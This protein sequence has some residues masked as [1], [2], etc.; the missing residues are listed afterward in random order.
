MML[1]LAVALGIA[2]GPVEAYNQGNRLYAAK[3]FPGAV[4]AYQEAL[5]AGHDARVHYNLGNALFRTGKI[6]EAIANY[7][8]AYYLAPRD[9]DTQTNLAFA[10][11]YRVDKLPQ[12]QGP[13]GRAAQRAL[14]CLSRREAALLAAAMFSL[15]GLMLSVWIVWR[16]AAPGVLAVLLGIAALYGFVAQQLWA[17][18]VAGRPAVVIEPE[19]NALSGPGEEF[20]QVMLLHDGTEVGIRETRGEYDLVQLPGGNGGWLKASALMRVY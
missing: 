7:R 4:L 11:A 16:R 9:R 8:R 18:E 15:A 12:S 5:K 14:R 13:I 20:K 3:D 19:V 6:G 17:G 1:A 2:L 10:R